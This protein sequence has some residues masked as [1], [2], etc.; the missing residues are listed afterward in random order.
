ME[1]ASVQLA[2]TLPANPVERAAQLLRI[3]QAATDISSL[4]DAAEA[5]DRLA[6]E[7]D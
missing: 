7:P 1:N 6:K 4:V 3:Q 5:L 2:H